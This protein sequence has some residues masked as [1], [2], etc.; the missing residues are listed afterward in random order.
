MKKR[1]KELSRLLYHGS[2]NKEQRETRDYMNDRSKEQPKR[3]PIFDE[4]NII[5]DPPPIFHHVYDGWA[6]GMAEGPALEIPA[7][8][9]LR[10]FN[11]PA[12]VERCRRAWR[13]EGSIELI[14]RNDMGVDQSVR[15]VAAKNQETDE[16]DILHLWVSIPGDSVVTIFIDDDPN[17]DESDEEDW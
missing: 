11:G 16:G 6:M 3:Q 8:T 7:L 15:I 9:R 13:S 17:E 14:Y 4:I 1:L 5:E 10:S 2:H 12:L